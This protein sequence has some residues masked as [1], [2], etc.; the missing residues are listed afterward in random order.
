MQKNNL[1]TKLNKSYLAILNIIE[2][3]D[4]ELIVYKDTGWRIKDILGHIATWDRE[5]TKSIEAYK[6][7]NEYAIPNFEDVEYNQAAYVHLHDLDSKQILSIFMDSRQ[8]FIASIEKLDEERLEGKLL[9]P[10][11][12]E[13]GDVATLVDYMIEHDDEHKDEIFNAIQVRKDK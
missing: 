6:S 7:G 13:H 8:A 9:Y 12:N 2:G 10:W 4:L 5:V 3:I 11:G 1:T